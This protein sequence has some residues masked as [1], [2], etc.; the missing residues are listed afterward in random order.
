MLHTCKDSSQSYQSHTV[1]L[2]HSLHPMECT[3][4]RIGTYKLSRSLLY[5]YLP[6]S[7]PIHILKQFEVQGF[8]QCKFISHANLVSGSFLTCVAFLNI[9]S[10]S[11]D[12]GLRESQGLGSF[13]FCNMASLKHDLQAS[14]KGRK[15]VEYSSR[16]ALGVLHTTR[17]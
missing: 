1:W 13:Y 7:I 12:S 6:Y 3:I 16:P 2:T 5:L 10:L 17:I 11:G 9:S 8:I 15:E 4:L 14:E